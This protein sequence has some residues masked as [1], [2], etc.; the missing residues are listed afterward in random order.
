MKKIL[1]AALIAMSFTGS[2]YAHSGGTNKSGC[3]NDNIHGG[4]HCHNGGSAYTP[5]VASTPA[6]RPPAYIE[7]TYTITEKERK[8]V[9]E[10]ITYLLNTVSDLQE[11][12]IK[13]H[14]STINEYRELDGKCRGGSGDEPDNE[15]ACKSRDDFYDTVTNLGLVKGYPSEYGYL[16]R[17]SKKEDV[18]WFG[19]LLDKLPSTLMQNWHGFTPLTKEE[20]NK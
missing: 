17:W 20:P 9:E 1:I 6:F 19:D 13:E 3:H 12:R 11:K 7:P 4:Y 10:T 18:V 5:H 16:Q 14:K 2:V 15:K 8:T